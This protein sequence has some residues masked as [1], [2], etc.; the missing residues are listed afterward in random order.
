VILVTIA[1]TFH[2]TAII[3]FLFLIPIYFRAFI[4]VISYGFLI[5][6]LFFFLF[7]TD[8]LSLALMVLPTDSIASQK[9]NFYLNSDQYRPI[10]SIGTG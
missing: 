4:K 1:S 9:L 8:I 10:L 5:S 3:G 2:I 7:S 6:G